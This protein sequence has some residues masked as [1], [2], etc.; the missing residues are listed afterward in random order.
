VVLLQLGSLVL[1]L[2]VFDGQMVEAENFLQQA[3]VT[4]VGALNVEPKSVF[5]TDLE[6]GGNGLVAWILE[7]GALRRDE[8]AHVERTLARR[9]SGASGQRPLWPAPTGA[10]HLPAGGEDRLI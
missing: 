9:S 8:R 7:G 5:V 4:V 1:V 10:G 6:A 2:D 3:Q